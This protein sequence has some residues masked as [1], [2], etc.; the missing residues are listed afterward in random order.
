MDNITK[1][2]SMLGI[3]VIVSIALYLHKLSTFNEKMSFFELARYVFIRGTVGVLVGL[4]LI[5]SKLDYFTVLVYVAIGS[6]SAPLILD[7]IPLISKR[8]IDKY[9][10]N[11]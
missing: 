6:V 9:S 7:A 2:F 5:D 8:L 1:I 3:S 10:K 4:F 11:L